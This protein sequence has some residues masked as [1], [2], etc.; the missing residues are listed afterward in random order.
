MLI[1]RM[2]D[3]RSGAPVGAGQVR[4]RVCNIFTASS[5]PHFRMALYMSL[6]AV[7]LTSTSAQCSGLIM[8]L[9]VWDTHSSRSA[10]DDCCCRERCEV[11]RGASAQAKLRS[12]HN[13]FMAVPVV[14]IMLSNHFPVA[15]YGNRYGWEIL[16]AL[17]CRL[18]SRQHHTTGLIGFEEAFALTAERSKSEGQSQKPVET[19]SE[20]TSRAQE[21]IAR[22]PS[23]P[24]SAKIR[25]ALGEL[26][27]PP[28]MHDC[29]GKSTGWM[30]ATGKKQ[31]ESTPPEICAGLYPATRN[32]RAQLLLG[33]HLDT[34]PNAGAY[35]GVLGIVLAS[36]CWKP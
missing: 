6:V 21:V 29:H 5:P 18:G 7:P 14:F 1:W 30:A 17:A 34:V 12:K 25:E 11:Q 16:V 23:W 10:Q 15:T 33:S 35:D 22:C 24:P 20:V 2:A 3:L 13:T 4:S 27:S 9:N 32:R 19:K 28:P 26:F 31:S 36:R 8:M